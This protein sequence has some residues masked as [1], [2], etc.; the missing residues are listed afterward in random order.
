MSSWLV[1]IIFIA[2]T[3]VAWLAMTVAAKTYKPDF[4]VHHKEP[5]ATVKPFDEPAPTVEE[6]PIIPAETGSGE[7]PAP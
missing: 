3:L 5:E 1:L 7:E 2:I 4:Q 6:V